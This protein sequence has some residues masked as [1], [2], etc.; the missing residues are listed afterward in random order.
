LIEGK[1]DFSMQCKESLLQK[2]RYTIVVITQVQSS[3]V[4]Q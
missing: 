3:G 1:N 4:S 2:N